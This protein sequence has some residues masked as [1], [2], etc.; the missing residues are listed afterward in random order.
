MK[1][2]LYEKE[3][4]LQ[5]D[6]LALMQCEKETGIKIQNIGEDSSLWELGTLVYYFAKR[7]AEITQAPF[8]YTCEEFLGL[9]ELTQMNFLV[10]CISSIMGGDTVQENANG[11]KKVEGQIA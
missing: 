9:I 3:F 6:L 4:S 2:S 8:K 11:Q 7:G 10:E 1:I 5:A